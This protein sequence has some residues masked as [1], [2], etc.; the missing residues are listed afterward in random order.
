MNFPLFIIGFVLFLG[1]G[2]YTLMNLGI[3]PMLPFNW[4]GFL[5]GG[6]CIVAGCF[7]LELSEL[8]DADGDKEDA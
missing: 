4:S 8:R 7:F 5:I 6:I 3:V 1:G 2:C